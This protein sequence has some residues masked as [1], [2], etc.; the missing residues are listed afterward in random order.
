MYVVSMPS[1]TAAKV[2]DVE[3]SGFK[4]GLLGLGSSCRVNTV[5]GIITSLY[6]SLRLL[7]GALLW[8]R[9]NQQF[10]FPI[11]S[12]SPYKARS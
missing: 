2:S 7:S 10:R 11:V 12:D 3:S 4:T 6:D 9:N 8:F 5:V 1:G